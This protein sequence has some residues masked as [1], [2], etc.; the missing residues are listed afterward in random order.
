[1]FNINDPENIKL[2]SLPSKKFSNYEEGN[3]SNQHGQG[4]LEDQMDKIDGLLISTFIDFNDQ[5]QPTI[6]LKIKNIINIVTSIQS[7]VII[8]RYFH[9]FED[10]INIILK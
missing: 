6:R 8:Q 9:L 10:K 3:G 7:N 5:N 1:V 4:Q 2:V